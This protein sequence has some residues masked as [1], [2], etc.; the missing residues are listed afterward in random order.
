MYSLIYDETF[1]ILVLKLRRSV[2][3]TLVIQAGV[4]NIPDVKKSGT[5]EYVL[6]NVHIII[7]TLELYTYSSF[8]FFNI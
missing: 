3:Q 6:Y 8:H 1:S 5:F 2:R 7:I 4:I